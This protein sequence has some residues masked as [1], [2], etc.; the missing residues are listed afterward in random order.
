MK[1]LIVVFS[2]LILF[3]TLTSTILAEENLKENEKKEDIKDKISSEK[4]VIEDENISNESSKK[5]LTDEDR[6]TVIIEQGTV[7]G[8]KNLTPKGK[9]FY[10]YHGI[11]FAMPPIGDLR[12]KVIF[13]INNI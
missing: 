12:L 1:L 2:G 4:L 3:A 5:V 6:L 13:I 8:L 7:K 9:T 11:P 10:T